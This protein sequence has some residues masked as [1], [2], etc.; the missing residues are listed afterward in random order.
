MVF[1]VKCLVKIE[2]KIFVRWNYLQIVFINFDINSINF[3]NFIS[4][5]K[6]HNFSFFIVNG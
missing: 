2:S 3:I 6:N 5:S 4:S 1:E